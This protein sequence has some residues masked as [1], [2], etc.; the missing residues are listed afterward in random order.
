MDATV[1]CWGA[2]SSG[3]AGQPAGSTPT[4]VSPLA[5]AGLADVAEI[6]AGE[7][8]TCARKND[9]T[10][11]CWGDNS[12]GQLGDG[13]NTARSTPAPVAS[14]GADIVEI[15]AGRFFVCARHA[16][17]LVS[18]WGG[19]GSGQ[20]GNS[21]AGD[22]TLPVSIAA[23]TDAAQLAAGYQ[24]ICALR[25]TGVVS[26]WGGNLHGELGDGTTMGSSTP[27]DVIDISQATSIAAGSVH[28]CARHAHG[29][30]CWGQNIVNQ[31][32]DGTTTDRWRPVS[33]AGFP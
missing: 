3:Q 19:G 2:N 13:T 16:G 6:Q 14:L 18:C 32:G 15:S 29:L 1:S 24:H 30:A 26:C 22:L 12:R 17:G 4:V 31:I 25:T 28:T 20:L 21:V 5:V 23:V 11:E 33:V 7:K 8:Y 9:R 10:V 27:V